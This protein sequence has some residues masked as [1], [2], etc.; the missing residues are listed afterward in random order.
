MISRCAVFFIFVF[1][2]I[3][4]KSLK[5]HDYFINYLLLILGIEKNHLYSLCASDQ[6]NEEKEATCRRFFQNKGEL[7][8]KINLNYI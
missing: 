1:Y 3:K 7:N 4:C 8:L 2:L 5:I 6:S